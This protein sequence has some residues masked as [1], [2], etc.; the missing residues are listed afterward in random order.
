MIPSHVN[1][2]F[3]IACRQREPRRDR[4]ERISNLGRGHENCFSFHPETPGGEDLK[5]LG[6]IEGHTDTGQQVQGC[7]VDP[8]HLIRGE[9]L[10][11][12]IHDWSS[13][14]E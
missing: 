9:G 3:R 12:V 8:G 14:L 7:I 11:P 4:V 1:A 13:V 5:G 2:F 10:H 6:F